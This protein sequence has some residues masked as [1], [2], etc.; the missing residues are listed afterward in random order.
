MINKNWQ[1]WAWASFSKTFADYFANNSIHCF[2]DGDDRQTSELTDFVEFRMDG[3]QVRELNS[4]NY[5]RLY[6]PVNILVKSTMNLERT[7]HFPQLIGTTSAAFVPSIDIF[8]YGNGPDDDQSL[9]V[10]MTLMQ[11]RLNQVR[12]NNFGQVDET[13]RVQQATVEG[14]Y[15]GFLKL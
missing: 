12:V 14:H 5:Y 1:R 2:V 13:V 11:D 8:K 15:L 10:C 9:L 3:L 4:P 6:L 7:H